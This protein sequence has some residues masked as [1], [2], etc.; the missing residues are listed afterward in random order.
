[1]STNGIRGVL[2]DKD[3]TLLDFDATWPPAYRA[4]AAELSELAGAPEL[5]ATLLRLGGYDDAGGLDHV[6]VLACG[7]TAEIVAFWAVRPELA[8]IPDVAALI[9]RRFLEFAR[10]APAVIDDLAGLFTR[11]RARGLAL[12]LATNDTGAAANEWLAEVGVH[13]LLDF[14]SGADS[15]FGAKPDPAVLHAFCAATDL[16]PAEVAVV[17]DAVKDIELAR[18]ANAGLAVSVLTGVTGRERLAARADHVLSS[19]AEL[20]TVLL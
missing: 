3:G 5:A 16:R 12:G 2:F 14:V 18:A 9:D 17:G 15:G 10:R 13:H 8:A 11:L 6:S 19:I 7:T 1:M 20:E 4:I